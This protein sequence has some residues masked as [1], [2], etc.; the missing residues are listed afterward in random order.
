MPLKDKRKTP[1]SDEKEDTSTRVKNKWQVDK[2]AQEKKKRK[3]NPVLVKKTEASPT[4]ASAVA[5]VGPV[6]KLWSDRSNV[7]NL[8]IR[9]KVAIAIFIFSFI[10]LSWVF[11]FSLSV[12]GSSSFGSTQYQQELTMCTTTW[13]S[14]A[15]ILPDTSGG[16]AGLLQ[17]Q[18]ETLTN[19]MGHLDQVN[20]VLQIKLEKEHHAVVNFTQ[21]LE[22]AH[23]ETES[24]LQELGDLKKA[25]KTDE[26]TVKT[27]SA[28]CAAQTSELTQQLQQC[29]NKRKGVE[30]ETQN[31]LIRLG[32]IT[33]E[34][35]G[36]QGALRDLQ[37]KYDELVRQESTCSSDSSSN[38]ATV[39]ESTNR[40][41]TKQD[42]TS[43]GS[44]KRRNPIVRF[45][46]RRGMRKS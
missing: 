42:E 41:A 33:S 11:S 39:D 19:R 40:G 14:L 17:K 36:G 24:V 46:K 5:P 21:K 29:E 23:I 25:T 44:M 10:V 2:A 3:K 28:K 16:S 38:S 7:G 32:A 18:V 4:T 34:R 15:A 27:L 1:G 35:D 30:N 43:D 26:A 45:F 6:L 20:R 31:I 22:T 13:S 9:E 12:C 37:L 8:S